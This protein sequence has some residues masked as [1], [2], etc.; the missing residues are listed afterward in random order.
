M[1]AP[2]APPE[3]TPIVAEAAV[4][5]ARVQA[6]RDVAVAEVHAATEVA[7]Q[8][9]ITERA[10][11]TEEQEVEWLR[12]ELAG[13]RQRCETNEAALSEHRATMLVMQEQH[14]QMIAQLAEITAVL[15][16]PTEQ[17]P[18]TPEPPSDQNPP[19]Q[20][21]ADG[22]GEAPAEPTREEPPPAS[23]KRKRVLFG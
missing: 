16:A 4:E 23:G 12:D 8:E 10:E 15:T 20:D 19:P 7:I 3:P 22:Q 21:D 11:L 5:I 6:E 9:A 14:Q 13:L 2:Q 1:V 17:S 18:P